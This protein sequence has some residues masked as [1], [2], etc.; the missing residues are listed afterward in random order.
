MAFKPLA[1][2]VALA[3]CVGGSASA[4]SLSGRATGYTLG[5]NGTTLVRI[6]DLTAPGMLSGMP[7]VDGMGRSTPL[8]ALAWRPMTRQLYG[9]SEQTDTV[10]EVDPATGVASVAAM[11]ADGIGVGEVGFDF[12]NVIDA[13]R[14]VSVADD[15]LV[16]FPNATPPNIARF[17]GL[18]YA[19]G[20]VNAGRDPGVFANAYTNAVPMASSTLQYVLDGEWDILATLA[21]NAG[22]LTT[23]GEIWA[24]GMMLDFTTTGGM[25]ILS[26]AEGD[27]TALAILTTA[28]GTG[29][30]EIGLMPDVMGRVQAKL[31]GMTGN[32]FGTLE[33]LA[34]AP[35][36][37]P[38]PVP[39]AV[40]LLASGLGSLALLRRRRTSGWG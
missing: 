5:N 27:N 21:N 37:A 29:L 25:D 9:F 17:T 4:A 38:V 32:S 31:L 11:T 13:A 6:G 34:V 2:A 40:W 18:F 10:Y 8:S 19:A 33:G 20:D 7:I 16:F 15:N 26:F 14:I 39:A 23:V 35:G 30:Y 3:L 1:G 22:T 12:N 24:D 28:T 36:P